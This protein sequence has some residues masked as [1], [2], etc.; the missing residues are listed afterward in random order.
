LFR[1]FG[2]KKEKGTVPY[3]TYF[4]MSAELLVTV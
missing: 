4:P 2:R 1:L 3:L